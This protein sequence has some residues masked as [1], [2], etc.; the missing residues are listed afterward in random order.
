[1]GEKKDVIGGPN[2]QEQLRAFTRSLLQDLHALGKMVSGG[3]LEEGVRRVGAEQEVF[4]VDRNLRPA[5]VAMEMLRRLDDPAHFTTELGLFNLEMNLDPLPLAGDCFSR[6][7]RQLLDLL[8]KAR[9]AAR[10]EKSDI[11]LTGI[12]PTIRKS[13]LG[14]DSMTP[15]PRYHALS[16]AMNR[17]RGGEFEIH[18]KGVDELHMR[19]DN[20]MVEACNA[21]FQTHLQ[22]GAEEFARLYNVAQVVAAPVLAAACNSPLMF[23]RRLWRETRIALF[24][25]SVD[26]RSGEH[27]FRERVPRVDF[28][29]RWVK[30]SVLDLF[31]D[32]ISRHR[33]LIA[34]ER[35]EDP[36][37]RLARGELPDLKALRLHNGTIYKWNRACYG[38]L[39]GRAHLRIE[40]RVMPSGPTPLDEVAN[41]AFW[42]GLML[43]MADSGE[44]VTRRMSFDD[45]RHNFVSAARHGIAA[46]FH[47]LDGKE[48]TA[49]KV[50]LEELLPMARKGLALHAVSS[51]DAD[52]YLG[53]IEERVRTGLTGAAWML[54]SLASMAGRG[55]EGELLNALTAGT[56]ARQW[57][58]TP[59]ARWSPARAEEGGGW[60]NN[61]I[62]V[63]QYMTTDLYT[64]HEDDAIDLVA[65]MMIW[66]R[67]RHVPVEDA[68]HRLVGLVSHRALL[69][70][71]A[72]VLQEG[73]SAPIPVSEVMVR[74]P[75][76]V[77][78]ETPTLRAMELMRRHDVGCLPVVKDGRLVGMINDG[79]L[80]E[81]A[82][83]LLEQHLKE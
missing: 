24:Q 64:V 67:T 38:I 9:A 74:D 35:E 75:W 28:G 57:D 73:T 14:I 8:G 50:I 47:W 6:M 44:D 11:V 48:T 49:R 10:A 1:M 58:G 43:A 83:K 30:G 22:V 33:V 70:V 76:S 37:A 39:E 16:E 45:A 55:T 4:L 23:G 62:K 69:R 27:H 32:G 26:T 7:E 19:H 40:N 63:E 2:E 21:S 52:R 56:I 41:A 34:T 3:L 42:Y 59:V 29:R 81:V 72:R 5:P 78:P 13:D 25:Q 65:N 68:Q 61:Y 36:M 80:M 17:L 71:L 15:L 53:V 77:A 79:A 20:V 46:E 12:L 31:Q 66:Q 82:G 51:D 60:R 18:L 54:K